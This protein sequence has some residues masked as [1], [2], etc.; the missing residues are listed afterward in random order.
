MY[1]KF[2][3]SQGVTK[4]PSQNNK[5]EQDEEQTKPF[6][7]DEDKLNEQKAAT[8]LKLKQERMNRFLNNLDPDSDFTKN[9]SD[10][11]T[12]ENNQNIMQDRNI[13]KTADANRTKL[14][15]QKQIDLLKMEF[16]QKNKVQTLESY[17]KKKIENVTNQWDPN[18]P[19]KQED[20][21]GNQ[22]VN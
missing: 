18:S 20:T 5:S 19:W 4:D 14:S 9:V 15:S 6:P 12:Q 11:L 22:L 7:N 13:E 10:L 21:S 2:S 3:K 16:A 17:E 1:E 8:F